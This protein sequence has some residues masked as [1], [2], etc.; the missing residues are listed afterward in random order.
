LLRSFD[1]QGHTKFP[2]DRGELLG[3]GPVH[4]LLGAFLG[5]I[6][7]THILAVHTY[8]TKL[9]L[10]HHLAMYEMVPQYA[11]TAFVIVCVQQLGLGE[12]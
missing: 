5:N 7:M 1:S 12:D 3:C 2:L 9:G 6:L 11:A 4:I 8:L 10:S